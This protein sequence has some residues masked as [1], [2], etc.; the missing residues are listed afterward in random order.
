MAS[1]AAIAPLPPEVVAQIKSSVS[2][3]S[4][5]GVIIQLL[6]NSLD[7][8]AGKVDVQVDYGRGSCIVEDDGLGI[9]PAEFQ[10]SGGLAKLHHTSKHA[11][12]TE[13]H[14]TQGC[15]LASLAALSLLSITSHHH[16]HRSHNSM[17]LSRSQVI[18]CRTPA[19]EAQHLVSLNHGTRVTVRNLFGD[20]PVRV[21]QR[22]IENAE[23]SRNP[24]DWDSL[25]KEVTALALSWQGP[26]SVTIKELASNTKLRTLRISSRPRDVN[27]DGA[28]MSHICSTL[29]QASFIPSVDTAS[30]VSAS[31]STSTVSIRSG[32][33]LDPA[34]TKGIQFMS[35]GIHPLSNE[36]GRN[37][38]FEEVNRLFANSSFG[39]V[40]DLPQLD[41]TEK[42]RRAEDRRY[43]SDG[44]TN[45]ELKGSGKGVDRWPM[46]YMRIDIHGPTHNHDPVEDVFDDE[47]TLISITKL[48]QAVIVEF[49]RS[50]NFTPKFIR[51]PGSPSKRKA[52]SSEVDIGGMQPP[53]N[54][55]AIYGMPGSRPQSP[56]SVAASSPKKR[57]ITRLPTRHP[58]PRPSSPFDIWPRVKSGRVLALV[59]TSKTELFNVDD[60]VQTAKRDQP[61]K[62]ASAGLKGAGK[63]S[64]SK[65]EKPISR[66]ATPLIS[67]SGTV[68]QLPFMDVARPSRRP[69]MA[70][71]KEVPISESPPDREKDDLVPW[72]DPT[73]KEN[74]FVNM[75]TGLVQQT[76]KLSGKPTSETRQG[77]RTLDRK[78]SLTAHDT[79]TQPHQPSTWLNSILSNWNNPVFPPAEPPIPQ[80]Q[81]DW[82]DTQ[83][84]SILHGHHHTCTQAAIDRAFQVSATSSTG[85]L[86][87]SG[88]QRARVIAQVDRKFILARMP[89]AAASTDGGVAEDMLVIIDQH[90]ADERCRI[91]A[92]MA[93]F[94]LPPSPSPGL[95]HDELVPGVRVERLE[96]SI[97]FEVAGAESELLERHRRHFADWGVLYCIRPGEGM[98]KVVLTALP[99][100]IAER[101]RLDPKMAIELVRREVWGVDGRGGAGP[102]RQIRE[103]GGADGEGEVTPDWVARMQGCPAGILDML[104]SRACRGAV[105]FNDVLEPQECEELVRRLGGCKFPFLCAHGRPSMVPLVGVGEG[106]GGVTMERGDEVGEKKADEDGG[107]FGRAFRMWKSGTRKSS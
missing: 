2:I 57:A 105:M 4:V 25:R 92:L 38:L 91:E 29:A 23:S 90:A 3:T 15:F 78:Y 19:P 65:I 54:A 14:G 59:K 47:K 99:P 32:I 87:K 73:T 44:F 26:V 49:L 8:S 21:K 62:R 88:L 71:K 17:A 45:K 39:I 53:G 5:N 94:C 86:S 24:K 7:A 75:R 85:R 11:S 46:F 101:C 106:V 72:T 67:K 37:I 96:K 20:M 79:P 70:P 55:K 61:S 56:A 35:F 42:K 97:V 48:L 93:D 102:S 58:S 1:S 6:K 60:G 107:G 103:T 30:W 69:G 76:P 28:L 82:T 40:D 36:D 27:D 16:L 83:T 95:G 104:N 77:L 64:A 34:P 10:P 80:I 63:D 84:Q 13:T 74:C 31:G 68:S 9:A 98:D 50:N 52:E 66:S 22:A 43:K 33:S 12:N 18:S 41:E 81:P 89:A 51:P 100:G